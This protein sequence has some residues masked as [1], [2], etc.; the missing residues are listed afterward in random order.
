MP[1]CPEKT[2]ERGWLTKPRN[3]LA[4]DQRRNLAKLC[5]PT[6]NAVQ[7]VGR[8]CQLRPI[9]HP[10]VDRQ[11][12]ARA[13][14]QPSEAKARFASTAAVRPVL[15]MGRNYWCRWS[16]TPPRTCCRTDRQRLGRRARQCHPDGLGTK[17]WH[18]PNTRDLGQEP[19][20]PPQGALHHPGRAIDGLADRG[21]WHLPTIVV[22]PPP[23]LLTPALLK[24]GGVSGRRRSH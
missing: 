22:N 10:E 5:Q 24:C 13:D 11:L 7:V 6:R 2:I 8:Q 19:V 3:G 12:P 20:A 1:F 21:S 17:P 15:Q 23:G 14:R 18:T 9:P 16:L 4:G